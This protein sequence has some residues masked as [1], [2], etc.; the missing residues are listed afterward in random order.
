MATLKA[1][2]KVTAVNLFVYAAED[3]TNENRCGVMVRDQ[4]F[5]AT[6][7]SDSSWLKI[8]TCQSHPEYVGKYIW[9]DTNNP[10]VQQTSSTVSVEDGEETPTTTD[11]TNTNIGV[12]NQPIYT[13]AAMVDP[14]TG[15]PQSRTASGDEVTVEPTPEIYIEDEFTVEYSP[16]MG[17]DEYNAQLADGLQV[18]NIRGVLGIPHQW[19]PIADVRT[20]IDNP[21]ANDSL[22]RIYSEK[23]LKAMPILLLTPGTPSFMSQFSRS[24]KENLLTSM[25]AGVSETFKSQL[26]NSYSGKYYSLKYAYIEYFKYVNAMLRSAAV[27]LGLENEV[28]DGKK[29]G[30]FNWLYDNS[31]RNS[32]DWLNQGTGKILGPYAGCIAFY[33]DCG[34]TS[35]DSFGNSTSQSQLASTLGSLSDTGRELNFLVGNVGSLTGLKVNALTGE[36]GLEDN[37]ANVRD[38]VNSI[39]GSGNIMSNILNKAQ[40]ILAGGRLIFPEIWSDSSFGRSYSCSMKLVAA[41]GDKLSIY[42]DWIVTV[43]HILGF[44]LPRQ[45]I[46]QSYFSPF[47]IRGTYKGVFNVDMAIMTDFSITRGAEA[48]WT[49]DGLPTVVEVSFTLKDLYEGM[50]MSKSEDWNDMNIMSNVTELDYIANMCG[51][52]INDQEV[53]RTIKL[54]KVLNFDFN[55][56]VAD[57]IRM[58][59]FG[60]I[61]QFFNQ[62]TNN[63][64]GMF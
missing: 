18:K 59:V 13:T 28:V 33:A 31:G 62:Q 63:L 35:S 39:L 58:N 8:E 5:V 37:M 15:Q 51:L 60:N 19:L 34:N 61:A 45:S 21:L 2:Y 52:N 9:R 55:N 40:T 23:F 4:D 47:L 44:M 6:F 41:T 57:N 36:E 3:I 38:T 22:G 12:A 10:Q 30:E 64:F 29:L 11:P 17:A 50:S 25:L 42:L 56:N 16:N 24:Q 32:E 46:E 7:T 26:L 14:V 49:V 48:E 53:F 54:W 20:N 43:C 27:F 1:R